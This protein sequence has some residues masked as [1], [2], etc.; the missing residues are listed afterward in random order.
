LC[1]FCSCVLGCGLHLSF[2][3]YDTT[4]TI[5]NFAPIKDDEDVTPQQSKA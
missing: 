2:L 4:Q 5:E 3:L 1:M